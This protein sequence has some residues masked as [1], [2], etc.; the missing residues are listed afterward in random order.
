MC[1]NK[2]NSEGYL[3]LLQGNVFPFTMIFK[4]LNIDLYLC[5]IESFVYQDSHWVK[6]LIKRSLKLKGKEGEKNK[7]KEGV[8]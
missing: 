8:K 3:C 2:G 6:S 5:L 7:E 1:S 4:N